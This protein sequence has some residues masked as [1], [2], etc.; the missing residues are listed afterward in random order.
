MK[1]IIGIKSI[2]GK[3]IVLFLGLSIVITSGLSLGRTDASEV[4]EEESIHS[5]LNYA[6]GMQDAYEVAQEV[7]NVVR[8]ENYERLAQRISAEK[9]AEEQRIEGLKQKVLDAK[10][11]AEEQKQLDKELDSK[12]GEPETTPGKPKEP[13]TVVTPNE[14]S[15]PAVTHNTDVSSTETKA[16]P[17][18][19]KE[20]AKEIVSEPTIKEPK[21][22]IIKEIPSI[23][24]NRIG[25]NG[26]YNSYVSL[27]RASTDEIQV[28]LDKGNVVAGFTHFN[29]NDGETTYFAGH[30][31]GVFNYMEANMTIGAIVTVSDGNGYMYDYQMV[32]SVEVDTDGNGVFST[33]GRSAIDVYLNGTGTESILI[34]YCNSHNGLMMMW[35]GIR[36]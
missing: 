14:D 7:D 30:N 2:V 22:E 28:S 16:I 27:G 9:L 20:P 29:P 21:K 8:K 25:L 17:A 35:Y 1:Y 4:I 34:Q 3:V 6:I 19:P 11:L 15:T 24:S 12:Q 36:I 18:A 23:G 10:R 5:T 32:D 13:E 31:P 26:T 33:L